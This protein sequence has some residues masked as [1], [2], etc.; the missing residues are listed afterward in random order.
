MKTVLITGASSG[1]GEATAQHFLK[2]QWRVC[3]TARQPDKLGS[4]SAAEGVVALP[5]DVTQQDSVRS[6]VAEAIRLTGRIDA[7]VNNAGVGLAGPLEAI[8]VADIQAH[9]ETNFFGAVRMIQ[10]LMPHFRAHSQGT[11][12]NVS[13]VA[14]RFGIPFLST[15]NASKFAVE[16]LSESLYYELLPFNIRIKLVEPGGIKTKFKQIFAQHAAYEPNLTAV[17]RRMEAASKPDSPLPLPRSVAEVIFTAAT[18]QTSR[19]RYP[20]ET[21]GA[22]LMHRLLPEQIWRSRLAKSFR[23]IQAKR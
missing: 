22:Q 9:F 20:V 13:S 5:L 3:A 10:E 23:L 15:Y 6:A 14:G 19:L 12:V 4:W 7:L 16:G 18:D 2:R 11:I 8:P 21:G 1:I 17:E